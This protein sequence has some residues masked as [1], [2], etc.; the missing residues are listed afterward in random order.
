MT[1]LPSSMQRAAD[2]L[3]AFQPAQQ[4]IDSH[5]DAVLAEAPVPTPPDAT[6]LRQLV[7]GTLRY[8]PLLT[9]FKSAFYHHCGAS[10][11]RKD[12]PLY[13]MLTYL[14]LLRIEELGVEQMET[15]L[16]A[17]DAQK[18]AVWAGFLFDEVHLRGELREEWSK[19]YDKSWV[20][21]RI[22]ASGRLLRH[23]SCRSRSS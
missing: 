2:I 11:L 18:A 4:T 22:G 19:V 13:A 20:D 10:A 7:Y 16:R 15:T 17:C 8:A 21:T 9:A 23:S 5:L 3:A 14:A 6:F 12:A 1:K